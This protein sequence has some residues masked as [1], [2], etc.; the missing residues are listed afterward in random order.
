MVFKVTNA[1]KKLWNCYKKKKK[2]DQILNIFRP[3]KRKEGHKVA[4][5]SSELALKQVLLN[6]KHL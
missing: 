6:L 1:Y 3:K 2:E 5:L 4:L